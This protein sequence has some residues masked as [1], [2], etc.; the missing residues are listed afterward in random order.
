MIAGR[1]GRAVWTPPTTVEILQRAVRERPQDEALRFGD[2][3]LDYTG[4]AARV[5]GLAQVL[6]AA[7]AS[8]RHVAILLPNGIDIC[9]A[10]FAAHAAG[11]IAVPLNPAYTPTELVPMFDD[12]RPA[13]TLTTRELAERIGAI[14]AGVI[15][16]ALDAP[17]AELK[18]LP[19]VSPDAIATLQ[20]TGG[21]TGRPKG[22]QLTHRAI[23]TN[24]AQREAVLPTLFGD[25][26]VLCTMPL[27]H[28]FAMAMGLHLAAYA[29]GSLVILPR[30]RPDWLV[31]TV[32][33]HGITR[34]PAGPTVFNSL[35]GYDGLARERLASL[36]CAYS[37]SAP[38][39]QATLERW[40]EMTGVPIYEGYGQ[41]EAGPV[42][43][44]HGPGM[45]LKQGSVGPALPA[46]EL[47]VVDGEIV[48][49]GP[50]VMAGY[51]DRPGE[52]REALRDGWLH[53]GD[54]GR[55]DADGYV[56]IEDRKK[57]MA[58]VGG[59]NVYPREI[60]EVL[61]RVPGVR[62]AAA[63]GVPDAYR[64][65]IIWAFVAGDADEGDIRAEC[66]RCLVA[67]KHPAAVRF[68]DALPR[69]PVGKVD[70]PALRALAVEAREASLV[71]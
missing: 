7:G 20:F 36:R 64:G 48:A 53:T 31:D 47:R 5:A 13:V 67:Y 61:A 14:D 69:T 3:A 32:E 52:T 2:E 18:D 55:I 17:P 34:L 16:T 41:S 65:E 50:Q 58:I 56:F 49:R 40:E 43:T 54:M 66:E 37:G 35:L 11:A 27:F 4:Y 9:V 1:D 25:E 19:P 62:E 21:T 26:R 28:S 10:I 70:K 71:A 68:V 51:L 12:T 6:I 57:D 45:M 60:D 38:L 39:A 24:V 8:G 42:L 59:F 29:A 15:V 23:A 22:V 63:V 44:Y 46:T 33:A 30:Y